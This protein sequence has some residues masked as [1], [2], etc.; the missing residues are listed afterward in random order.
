MQKL[1]MTED[2]A[3]RVL[4]EADTPSPAPDLL[5]KLKQE[6]ARKPPVLA[7]SAG[8]TGV[9]ALAGILVLTMQPS[10]SLADVVRKMEQQQQY[11][12]TRNLFQGG[13]TYKTWR[14]L[15]NGQTWRRRDTYGLSDRTIT[16]VDQKY[17]EF[18]YVDVDAPRTPTVDEFKPDRLLRPGYTPTVERNVQWNGRTV[19]IFTV[20]GTFGKEPGGFKDQVI[21]DPKTELPIQATFKDFSDKVSA[22]A[23][24]DY[25]F[26]PPPPS[27]F[28]PPTIPADTKV[29][30]LVAQ[31]KEVTA[32]L[33]RSHCVVLVGARKYVAVLVPGMKD[34]ALPKGW[35][36]KVDG[37]GEP[38]ELDFAPLIFVSA[39]PEQATEINTVPIGGS[40]WMTGYYFYRLNSTLPTDLIKRGNVSGVLI[41]GSSTSKLHDVKVIE[42][43]NLGE[44]LTG[45][46]PERPAELWG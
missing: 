17:P 22:G 29:F 26:S 44:L 19:D 11:T 27:A 16:F 35:K 37:V 12:I 7:L 23:V 5:A 13:K 46:L 18:K 32:E 25:D 34:Q 2:N 36:L 21:V 45:F 6:P 39:N 28:E 42:T 33:A 24:T 41:G 1:P 10:V 9:A 43:G 4:R 8:L 3:L 38:L 20:E 40:D 14:L 31:R 30:D 15:R